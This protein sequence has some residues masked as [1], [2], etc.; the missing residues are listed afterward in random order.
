MDTIFCC[1]TYFNLLN[2]VYSFIFL[3]PHTIL[4]LHYI[5]AQIYSFYVV[6]YEISLW[7]YHANFFRETSLLCFS[8]LPCKYL[9]SLIQPI[10]AY[11]DVHISSRNTIR[12]TLSCIFGTGVVSTTLF[13]PPLYIWPYA[14]SHRTTIPTNERTRLSY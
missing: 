8:T 3:T 1:I 5:C 14:L 4:I 13:P 6:I 7:I 11:S 12:T 9:M 2:P 10:N